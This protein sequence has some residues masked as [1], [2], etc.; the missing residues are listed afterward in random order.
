[1]AYLLQKVM[2][3]STRGW[4]SLRGIQTV[5]DV[6][7][8]FI[9][10]GEKTHDVLAKWRDRYVSLNWRQFVDKGWRWCRLWFIG[11]PKGFSEH[12]SRRILALFGAG[13]WQVG[14][15]VDEDGGPAI[16]L[17]CG[18]LGAFPDLISDTIA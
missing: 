15:L 12:G 8:R 9:T 7:C 6:L 16:A 4:V 5:H 2:N 10:D 18:I 13:R 1:M 11:W 3:F 17:I 14:R